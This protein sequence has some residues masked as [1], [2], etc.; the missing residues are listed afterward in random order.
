MKQK[1]ANGGG[2]GFPNPLCQPLRHV[3]EDNSLVDF[4]STVQ[5]AEDS[6]FDRDHH[7]SWLVR[8]DNRNQKFEESP[9]S[10]VP[11]VAHEIPVL[12]VDLVHEP[13]FVVALHP[14]EQSETAS[15]KLVGIVP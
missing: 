7:P 1:W 8:V 3:P 2:F 9:L 5:C 12:G 15:R 6:V 14:V 11:V 13:P 4:P 10:V